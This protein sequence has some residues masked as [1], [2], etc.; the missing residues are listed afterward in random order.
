MLSYE[1]LTWQLLSKVFDFEDPGAVLEPVAGVEFSRL[2][3]AGLPNFPE[4]FWPTLTKAAQG[5]KLGARL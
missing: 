5:D 3:R 2:A 4:D 1:L